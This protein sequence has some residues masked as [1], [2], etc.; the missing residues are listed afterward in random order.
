MLKPVLECAGVGVPFHVTYV[1]EE[2]LSC[3]GMLPLISM[4]FW[5][6]LHLLGLGVTGQTVHGARPTSTAAAA[7]LAQYPLDP[8]FLMRIQTGPRGRQR[9][10]QPTYKVKARM[11]IEEPLT[12]ECLLPRGYWGFVGTILQGSPFMA[13]PTMPW[14]PRRP[15]LGPGSSPSSG[16]WAGDGTRVWGEVGI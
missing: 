15:Q 8:R 10:Q 6:K 5:V 2:F 9:N 14:C 1:H 4:K 16:R 7:P 3:D 12:K 13:V 11:V